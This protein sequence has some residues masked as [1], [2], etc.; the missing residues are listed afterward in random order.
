L[1]IV[2]WPM[3]REPNLHEPPA[4]I[5]Q[6]PEVTYLMGA[7]T[8][9]L[10][11]GFAAGQTPEGTN[12]FSADEKASVGGLTGASKVVFSSSLEDPPHLGQQHAR[13]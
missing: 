6:E 11:S 1:K 13:T 10:M 12:E 9:R 8:Y 4:R 3:R 7:K 5:A 2:A